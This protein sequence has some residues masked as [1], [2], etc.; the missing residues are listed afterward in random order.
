MS[1]PALPFLPTVVPGGGAALDVGFA[2]D[3]CQRSSISL[4]IDQ[5][6]QVIPYPCVHV[7]PYP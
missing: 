4:A 3:L 6:V 2:G 7:I 1:E 5:D